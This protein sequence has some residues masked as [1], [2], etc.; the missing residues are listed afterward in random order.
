MQTHAEQQ[1]RG[2]LAKVAEERDALQDKL[3]QL[4]DKVDPLKHHTSVSLGN[5]DGSSGNVKQL[6]FV[7]NM[8]FFSSF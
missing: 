2:E 5:D 4:Q 1:H 8:L 7:L 3:T 6:P